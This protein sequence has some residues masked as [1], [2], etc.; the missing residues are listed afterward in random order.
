MALELYY[1][2]QLRFKLSSNSPISPKMKNAILLYL[3]LTF[4]LI[5]TSFG[6]TVAPGIYFEI[7]NERVTTHP[8]FGS[9]PVYAFDVNMYASFS[10]TFHSRGQLYMSYNTSK[11]G[12]L[13]NINNNI[14][15]EPGELLNDSLSFLGTSIAKYETINA[16]DR[17]RDIFVFT[18]Q[19]NFL[20]VPPSAM[21]HNEVL[22]TPQRLYTVYLR[23]QNSGPNANLDFVQSLMRDQQFMLD[24]DVSTGATSEIPYGNAFLPVEMLSFDAQRLENRTVE[25]SWATAQ[26]I[27]NDFFAVE[28]RQENGD[29]FSIGEVAGAGNSS[30]KQSY[31]F[32][33]ETEMS[34]VNYYR[35]KQ[36]DFDGTVSYSD[37]IKVNMPLENNFAV[38]PS[39]TSGMARLKGVVEMDGT[40][41]VRIMDMTGKEMSRTSFITTGGQGELSL[42]LSNYPEGVYIVKTQSPLGQ[43]HINRVVKV[44]N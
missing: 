6:Q 11:F 2:K 26:E 7:A 39:P 37:V 15:F 33:D 14:A 23:I 18:W 19:G 31:T 24:Y 30:E 5:G 25:L 43:V 1:W 17:A 29:F 3:F 34:P 4:C 41:Q 38:F 21:A 12:Q 35:L 32:L 20:N 22:A 27:N 28:K 16:V 8:D 42:N 40:Y 13:V 36:V 10:G 9:D 44:R